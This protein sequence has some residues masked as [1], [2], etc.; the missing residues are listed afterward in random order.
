MSDRQGT[1]HNITGLGDLDGDG[2]LDVVLHNVRNES[3]FT[4]FASTTLWIN[5]GGIQGG[6]PGVF[7]S[8]G[9]EIINGSQTDAVFLADLD[10]GGDLGALA[11]FSVVLFLLAVYTLAR[12]I[13]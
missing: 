12:R 5:Q 4:A 8:P 1:Y 7:A 2:D 3:E 11:A 6:Q 10:N 13:E 9:Q